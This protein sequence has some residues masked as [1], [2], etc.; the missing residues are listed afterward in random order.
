M[1]FLDLLWI[2]FIISALQPVLQQKYLEMQR[3]RLLTRFERRRGSRAI[4]LVHRQETMSWLGFPLMRYI[5]INDSEEVLQAI[6]LTNP[7]YPIDLIL[8]TP[9]GLVLAAGQ[10]AHALR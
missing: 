2:F 4:A 7:D 6:Q 5:D 9:G 3:L 10:I 8:H 1:G